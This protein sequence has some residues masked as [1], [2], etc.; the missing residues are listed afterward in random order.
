MPRNT[1]RVKV[2]VG[3][4][5]EASRTVKF[6]VILDFCVRY[7]LQQHLRKN[8]KSGP[9]VATFLLLRFLFDDDRLGAQPFDDGAVLV[10]EN[11]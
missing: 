3:H 1:F 8:Q 4:S 11:L 9:A 7:I 6:R 2:D 5:A 10:Q